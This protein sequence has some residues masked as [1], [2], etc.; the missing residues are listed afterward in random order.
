M[1]ERDDKSEV[2]RPADGTLGRRDFLKRGA[3]TVAAAGATAG[4]AWWLHDPTGKA[5]LSQPQPETLKNYFAGVDYRVDAPRLSIAR[6]R[7]GNVDWM[8]RA[9]VGGLGGDAG[10]GRFVSRGDIVLVKPNVGF[11][12]APKYGAN[13]NPDVVRSVV[14]LCIEA[15]ADRVVVA[16]NPIES[17]QSCFARSGIRQA[18]LEEGAKVTIPARIHFRPIAVRPPQ[19]D[20]TP[21]QPDPTRHEALGTW[22]IFWEP[23]READKVIGIPVIKDH[24]LCYASM[25]MKNW[26]GLLGGRRNQFHQAIHDIISDLGLMMSPT[27]TIADGTRVMTRN[28]PTGGRLD[29]VR[30]MNTVVA[31][32]DPLACDAWCYQNLLGRDPAALRYL[33]LAER[34]F[35]ETE[36]GERSYA[37]S[38]RFGTRDWTAYRRQGKIAEQQSAT[39]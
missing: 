19:P 3:V 33:E 28:G 7:A 14:R 31:S 24:N 27:L 21:Y 4:A 34:K 35:G 26:Y 12:R 16:D 6:G 9:A 39:L 29:D 11:E 20:G 15:G 5:G 25:G 37:E 13:T 38:R 1:G 17:P 2:V 22:P 36:T 8:V 30:Q 23:L 32:V 18:A 10:M